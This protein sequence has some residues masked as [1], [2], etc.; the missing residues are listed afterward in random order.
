MKAII[1]MAGSGNRISQKI[2]NRPKSTVKIDNNTG[3]IDYTLDTLKLLGLTDINL[4]VGYMKDFVT[5]YL[6]KYDV[7]MYYNPFYKITNS[8]SS[9]WFAKDVLDS[10]DDVMIMNADCFFVQKIYEKVYNTKSDDIL[11]VCDSSKKEHDT[12]IHVS[13]NVVDKYFFSDDVDSIDNE[14]YPSLDI[15]KIPKSKN[16]LFKRSLEKAIDRGMTD[17]IFENLLFYDDGIGS[18]VRP[19]YIENLFWEEIDYYENYVNIKS[20]LEKRE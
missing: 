16:S 2:Q 15:I 18:E 10:S 11:I 1:M 8:A 17:I 19:L 9:L 3:L 14:T 12:F 6:S 20:Y 7:K 5:S 13:N 4:C